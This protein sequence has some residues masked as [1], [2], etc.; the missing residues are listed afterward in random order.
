[1]LG[2][3][4]SWWVS[5]RSMTFSSASQASSAISWQPCAASSER[6][7][8]CAHELTA[9]GAER[10][11]AFAEANSG[12]YGLLCRRT[13]CRRKGRATRAGPSGAALPR[14]RQAG[15]ESLLPHF[16]FG[17]GRPLLG[18]PGADRRSVADGGRIPGE[19]FR[20]ARAW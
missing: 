4:A 18:A 6:N 19:D 3:R 13:T 12:C 8:W 15:L 17:G 7:G 20:R 1:W 14:S 5:W 11:D 9:G 2:R 10:R 16:G